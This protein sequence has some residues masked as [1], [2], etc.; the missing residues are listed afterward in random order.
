MTPSF[1]SV[2][3]SLTA[4]RSAGLLPSQRASEGR[5]D[6]IRRL[7]DFR[8]GVPRGGSFW[9]K[10]SRRWKK[11][12]VFFRGLEGFD[13]WFS[14]GWK[15]QR[16]EIRSQ[17]SAFQTLE[18]LEAVF[19]DIGKF[20][21]D[22]SKGW[23]FSELFFQGLEERRSRRPRPRQ[24]SPKGGAATAASFP[25][26]ATRDEAQGSEIRGRKSEGVRLRAA[27]RKRF[28]AEETLVGVNGS[29]GGPPA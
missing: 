28:A 27:G 18:K 20:G 7:E 6:F 15:F 4:P 25:K 3:A 23:N 1:Q 19:P 12:K 5:K 16:S 24:G 17:R 8:L 9:R 14:E 13:L 11:S 10:L 26:K 2:D 21:T 29:R 22:F